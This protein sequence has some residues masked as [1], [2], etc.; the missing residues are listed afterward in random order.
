MT[1]STQSGGHSDRLDDPA[2]QKLP[3]LALT[4]QMAAGYC[5]DCC[6]AN[7][8]VTRQL[9]ERMAPLRPSI[10]GRRGQHDLPTRKS[11]EPVVVTE[12]LDWWVIDKGP[13]S[14]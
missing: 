14:T 9:H 11:E 6:T 2:V 8:T 5:A 3:E 12:R 10:P 7:R 4:D 13:A 1:A